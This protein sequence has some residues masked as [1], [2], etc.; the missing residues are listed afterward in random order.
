VVFIGVNL[1]ENISRI[2][3]MMGV[4]SENKT[5]QLLKSAYDK[6]GFNTAINIVG[7]RKVTPQMVYNLELSNKEKIDFIKSV[8]G[9][10]EGLFSLSSNYL[11][12]LEYNDSDWQFERVDALSTGG[13]V[14]DVYRDS[15]P[16][17]MV[18]SYF[19][20]YPEMFD[21]MLDD[22]FFKMIDILKNNL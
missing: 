11:Q 8:V 7:P 17:Q 2:K 6:A 4:L 20:P 13:A 16:P 22:I 10:S 9:K 18:D 1:Q 19:R 12:P 3:E 15:D 21:S 5:E 14:I